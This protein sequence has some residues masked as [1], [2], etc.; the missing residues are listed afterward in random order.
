MNVIDSIFLGGANLR[1]L[2]MFAL[3]FLSA[4]GTEDHT[5]IITLGPY[6]Q[7]CYGAHGE[8]DCLM[9]YNEASGNWEFFYESIQGFDFESGFIYRLEVRL[10]DRGTDIQDVGRYA[11]HLVKIIEKKKAPNDFS[12]Q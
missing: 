1:Y 3:L 2:L 12:Y 10:E 6:I 5:E 4:C 8:R 9:E 11:Y 7:R